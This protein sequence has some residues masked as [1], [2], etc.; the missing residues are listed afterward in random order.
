MNEKASLRVLN[1]SSD[2]LKSAIQN[3]KWLGLS[4]IVFVL[5][6]VGPVAEAQQPGKI[7]RIGFLDPSTAAGSAVLWDVFRQELGKLGWIEGKNIAFEYRFGE[8]KG[9]PHVSALAADLVN[10]KVDL[11]VVLGRAAGRAAKN[12]PR[13]FPS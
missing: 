4:V 10:L 3:P 11:I 2:N 13:P 5:V 6:V 7:F 12:A 1:F 9:A 8:N